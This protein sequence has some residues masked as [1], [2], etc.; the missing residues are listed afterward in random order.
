MA[1]ICTIHVCGVHYAVPDICLHRET[2][3][4]K[5]WKTKRR[6]RLHC[7]EA[8]RKANKET[9]ATYITNPLFGWVNIVWT[10]YYR[11]LPSCLFFVLPSHQFTH[12]LLLFL[13]LFSFFLYCYFFYFTL[14]SCC[15]IF[16]VINGTSPLIM[17]FLVIVIMQPWSIYACVCE[18][19]VSNI[20]DKWHI[21]WYWFCVSVYT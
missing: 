10:M 4:M 3:E 16:M 13:Q 17:L 15:L 21:W 19:F 12:E 9:H 18:Y 7:P 14:Q 6:K 11:F 8:N 2:Q 20:T 5:N 1:E